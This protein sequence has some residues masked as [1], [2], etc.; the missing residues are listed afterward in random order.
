MVQASDLRHLLGLAARA[1]Q[2]GRGEQVW[3]LMLVLAFG[4]LCVFVGVL[5]WTGGRE[6]GRTE[7]R[8][9]GYS[10][11]YNVGREVARREWDT[12]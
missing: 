8:E 3:R 5:G 9:V 6:H 4:A 2:A 7:G 12:D 10:E 1:P 11:G